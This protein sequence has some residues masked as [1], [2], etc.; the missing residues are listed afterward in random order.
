MG[1]FHNQASVFMRM[2]ALLVNP[3]FWILTLG[4]PS[5]KPMVTITAPFLGRP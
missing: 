3:N 4:T 1:Q 2:D 5:G